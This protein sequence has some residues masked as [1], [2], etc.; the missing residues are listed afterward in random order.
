MCLEFSFSKVILL[1]IDRNASPDQP[2][3]DEQTYLGVEYL[4]MLKH[5]YTQRGQNSPGSF[6]NFPGCFGL[7]EFSRDKGSIFYVVLHIVK[8]ALIV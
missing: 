7:S 8:L 4:F 5:C 1:H 2:C 3:K 6:E